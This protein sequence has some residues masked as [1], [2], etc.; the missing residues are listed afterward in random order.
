[1]L[2][3]ICGLPRAGKTTLSKAFENDFTVI[4][5]DSCGTY[6]L[7][8][9]LHVNA[10][11][12]T[13]ENIVVDGVYNRA[14]QR[15]ALLRAYKGDYTKCIWMDTPT[16]RKKTRDGYSARCELEFEPPTYDE[17]WNE[18]ERKIDG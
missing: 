8:R 18:I 15:I 13:D 14:C 10:K 17:G 4:H 16:E 3:L 5:L 9:Y 1:M 7:N 12:G 11:A 2:I 6:R